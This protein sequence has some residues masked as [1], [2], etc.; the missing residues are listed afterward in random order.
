MANLFAQKNPGIGKK[1]TPTNIKL[2]ANTSKGVVHKKAIHV[3][4]GNMAAVS[5]KLHGGNVKKG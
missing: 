4:S 1:N 2:E 3:P 5:K